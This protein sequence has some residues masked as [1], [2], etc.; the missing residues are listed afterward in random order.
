MSTPL[1]PVLSPRSF[2]DGEEDNELDLLE[3]LLEAPTTEVTIGRLQAVTADNE[4]PKG[5]NAPSSHPHRALVPF[6]CPSSHPCG[7]V[8]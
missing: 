2:S 3:F 6:T 7:V 5:T 8:C 4:K 1:S